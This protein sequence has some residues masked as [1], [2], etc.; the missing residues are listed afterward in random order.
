MEMFGAVLLVVVGIVLFVWRSNQ[1]NRKMA[2]FVEKAIQ[3]FLEN[4]NP[5]ALQFILIAFST[6]VGPTRHQVVWSPF[7]RASAVVGDMPEGANK[8]MLSLRLSNLRHA[9]ESKNWNF[10]DSLALKRQLD[11]DCFSAWRKFDPSIF[12][13]L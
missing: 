12:E 1:H 10:R 11:S 3:R 7:N 8:E 13:R 9:L 4:E 2:A 5:I 6:A